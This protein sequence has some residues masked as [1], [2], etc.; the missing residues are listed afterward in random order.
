MP[1]AREMRQEQVNK[2]NVR[3]ENNLKRPSMN[4]LLP[5]LKNLLMNWTYFFNT[6]SRTLSMLFVG[7]LLPFLPKL[8]MLKFGLKPEETGYA[9]AVVYTPP[10]IGRS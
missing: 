10:M 6:I 5:E 1:G 9:L 2:G 4:K 3:K 7:A 8:F